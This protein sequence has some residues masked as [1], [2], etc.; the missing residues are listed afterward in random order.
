MHVCH[1]NS[2]EMSGIKYKIVLILC[3]TKSIYFWHI[4]SLIFIGHCTFCFSLAAPSSSFHNRCLRK[5]ILCIVHR[6]VLLIHNCIIVRIFVLIPSQ[7]LAPL[8]ASFLKCSTA[9]LSPH[10]CIAD[11]TTAELLFFA[12]IFRLGQE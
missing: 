4:E 6:A 5:V 7:S 11:S 8:N 12:T 9:C 10:P 2:M 1:L 3:F